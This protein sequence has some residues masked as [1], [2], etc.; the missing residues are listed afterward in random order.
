MPEKTTGDL[1]EPLQECGLLDGTYLRT[2]DDARAA[3]YGQHSR[4][5]R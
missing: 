1:H 2:A 4:Q 5:H 3:D